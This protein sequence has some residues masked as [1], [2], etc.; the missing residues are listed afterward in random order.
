MKNKVTG[1]LAGLDFLFTLIWLGQ[2]VG[3]Q[4]VYGSLVEFDQAL[5]YAKEAHWFFY[6]ATYINAILLTLFG[7][8]LYASLYALL[9]ET[10]S[11]WAIVGLVFVPLYG[12]LALFSYLCQLTITPALITQLEDPQ[13]QPG[14]MFLLHHLLQSWPKSTLILFDQFSYFLLGFPC[15]I[16]GLLMWK[17]QQLRIPGALFAISGVLCL[18]IGPGVVARILVL[19]DVPSMAGGVLS[20]AATGW[21]AVSL[22]RDGVPAYQ[23][24]S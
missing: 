8:M 7:L 16:Y 19:I 24:A 23:P 21:L 1:I 14:A 18:L 15:L 20:I 3:K 9:K 22:L 10:Q 2:M 13:L 11:A 5:S 6:S 12:I 4:L 17:T